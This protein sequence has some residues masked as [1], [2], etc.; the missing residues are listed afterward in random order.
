L[1]LI[2]NDRSLPNTA[3]RRQAFSAQETVDP[4]T[5]TP[6]P[7]SQSSASLSLSSS[8]SSSRP[9]PPWPVSPASYS[10]P[11]TTSK[12]QS[13]SCNIASTSTSTTVCPGAPTKNRY[14]GS[15]RRF[16][17]DDD[18]DEND[19]DEDNDDDNDEDNDNDN[20]NDAATMFRRGIRPRRLAF[21]DDAIA[22]YCDS[23]VEH[24]G[25]GEGTG[26]GARRNNTND[27]YP[28]WNMGISSSP[29]SSPLR[30]DHHLVLGL[31]PRKQRETTPV[32][33]GVV[34]TH[35][36]STSSSSSSSSSLSTREIGKEAVP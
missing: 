6:T 13:N 35:T 29:R 8:L 7:P 14:P 3:Q 22:D 27:S 34:P 2:M 5:P 9:L 20:D 31:P 28:I 23:E 4:S 10:S 16:Y 17:R 32:S 30:H 33:M 36:H 11:E 24:E 19:N 26:T 21:H 18:D 15:R 25:T 12:Q 1:K